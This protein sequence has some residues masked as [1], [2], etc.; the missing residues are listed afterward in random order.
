MLQVSLGSVKR[1]FW[2]AIVAGSSTVDAAAAAGVSRDTGYVWFTDAGG[3]VPLSLVE[4]SGRFLSIQDRERIGAGVARGDSIRQ[5]ARDIRRH[6]STVLRELRRNR[7]HAPRY[8]PKLITRPPVHPA[9]YSPSSAQA[10]ADRRQARPKPGKLVVNARLGIEVQRRLRLGHSPQQISHRLRQDFPDDETMRISH[11]AIYRALYVQGR[12]LLRAELTRALRTGRTT[13][14]PRARTQQRASATP[15][16]GKI[17]GMVMI[18]Q[19]PADVADRA[20]PGHWEGD[21]ILGKDSR[22]QIG[23]LVERTSRFVILLHL[24]A[25]RDA[26][27]VAAQMITQ[28]RDLPAHLRRSIT[29]DQGSEMAAHARIAASLDLREGVFFC[30]PHSPWQRGTNENTNGLLRQYFPKGTVLSGYTRH[31]LDAVAA[32][33][34]ARPRQ[35]LNWAT[36]A[37]VLSQLLLTPTHNDGALTR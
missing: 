22:S 31:Y 10:R 1:V 33:L 30:D 17:P 5:I 24:P 6:P 18:S 14:T 9:S 36:P 27:T 16:V 2:R 4:A 15:G 12:G 7:G 3:M 13:R 8:R 34:N 37:E 32:E 20:V 35:T 26:D 23:T 29:W 19:R 11:E 21:L 28:M 25:R